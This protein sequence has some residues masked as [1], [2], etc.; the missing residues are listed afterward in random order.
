MSDRRMTVDANMPIYGKDDRDDQDDIAIPAMANSIFAGDKTAAVLARQGITGP[1]SVLALARV[2]RAQ[3]K[4]RIAIHRETS[5]ILEGTPYAGVHFGADGKPR[6]E[7]SDAAAKTR[8]LKASGAHQG[9]FL[10]HHE[11]YKGV[12]E[13]QFLSVHRMAERGAAYIGTGVYLGSNK[14]KNRSPMGGHYLPNDEAKGSNIHELQH[15][16]QGV[17]GFASGGSPDE[18]S[19]HFPGESNALTRKELYRRLAGEQEA[20]KARVRSD[21]TAEELRQLPPTEQ[22]YFL[23]NE[24]QIVIDRTGKVKYAPRDTGLKA[25]DRLEATGVQSRAPTNS[26]EVDGKPAALKRLDPRKIKADASTFQFKSGGDQS[27]VTDRLRSVKKWDPVSAGK[28][29]VFERKNGEHVIADGHQRRGLALRAVEAGQK[30]VKMDAYVFREKDGWSPE[31]VR[32]I[33]AMKNIREDSGTSLDMAKVMRDRPDLVDASIPLSSGKV[34][35]AQGLSRLSNDAFGMVANGAVKPD[36]AAAVGN[37]LRG[38]QGRDA[39]LLKEMAKAKVTSGQHARLYVSQA[40][41]APQITETHHG[42]FGAETMQR[43]LL[44]ER[45]AVLNKAMDAIRSDKRIFGMLTK[46]EGSIESA[47]NVLAKG[48]NAE[49]ATSAAQMGSLVEKLSTMTGPVSSMLDRAARAVAEGQKPAQAA[50]GFVGD[51]RT[52]MKTGGVGALTG[53]NAH[54]GWGDNARAASADVRAQRMADDLFPGPTT[55]DSLAAASRSKAAKGRTG[56]PMTEGL[57]GEQHKQTDLVDMAKAAIATNNGSAAKVSSMGT[58]GDYVQRLKDTLGTDKHEGVIREIMQDSSLGKADLAAIAKEHGMHATAS[59]SKPMIMRAIAQRHNKLIDAAHGSRAIFSSPSDGPIAKPISIP[60]RGKS[61]GAQKAPAA[62]SGYRESRVNRIMNRLAAAGDTPDHELRAKA[63]KMADGMKPSS[64]VEKPASGT[65][66]GW[67]DSARSA[68]LTKREENM[69]GKKKETFGEEITRRSKAASAA[70]DKKYKAAKASAA[71]P[72]KAGNAS[73]SRAEILRM[74]NDGIPKA[75]RVTKVADARYVL[76]STHGSIDVAK[77]EYQKRGMKFGRVQRMQDG[78]PRLS[79][80][81]AKT[82]PE[83]AKK[84]GKILNG[85]PTDFVAEGKSNAGDNTQKGNGRVQ[86]MADDAGAPKRARAPKEV[87]A[88]DFDFSKAKTYRKTAT[89]SA[90]QIKTAVGGESVVTRQPSKDGGSFVE[91]TNTAKPGDRIVTRSPGDSYVIPGEKFSKLYEPHPDQPGVYRSTNV[92]KAIRVNRDVSI[93]APWGEVQNI[94]KGGVIFKSETTGDVYGN[95][96]ETFN[97]DFKP[98]TKAKK[99][100]SRLRGTQNAT[101]QQAII[102]NRAAASTAGGRD[103]LRRAMADISAAASNHEDPHV[104]TRIASIADKAIKDHGA[105]KPSGHLETALWD[106]R[107][108]ANME[109]SS[110]SGLRDTALSTIQK[111]A[112]TKYIGDNQ[113][114]IQGNRKATAKPFVAPDPLKIIAVRNQTAASLAEQA[115]ATGN[116]SYGGQAKDL[117][118]RNDADLRRLS[119]TMTPDG[120]HFP[121][122]HPDSAWGKKLRDPATSAEFQKKLSDFNK[123]MGRVKESLGQVKDGLNRLAN[124][125]KAFTD[126]LKSVGAALS[127]K[128]GSVQTGS[129]DNDAHMGMSKIDH[130]IIDAIRGVGEGLSG[131][132]RGAMNVGVELAPDPFLNM[133]T[134]GAASIPAAAAI[135]VG[136]PPYAAGKAIETGANMAE[137]VSNSAHRN[138]RKAT[139]AVAA[140]GPIAVAANALKAAN[141]AKAKGESQIKAAARGAA[142]SAVG[143]GGAAV[144]QSA[145]TAGLVKF[146]IS[147][148]KAIPGVNAAMMAGGAAL[149]AYNAEKGH[150]LAGAAKGA[151]DMSLPGMVVNTAKDVGQA[152]SGRMALNAGAHHGSDHMGNFDAANQKFASAQPESTGKG[153]SKYWGANSAT[154]RNNRGLAPIDGTQ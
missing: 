8:M 91:T 80:S 50:R 83:A 15:F 64:A 6:F 54:V 57:F 4:N 29:I 7:I 62:V 139:A 107:A 109:R 133:A 76:E 56:D 24:Q 49:R 9:E 142:D 99:P 152:V 42:L 25:G 150:R 120:H 17:E 106:I 68:S 31:D 95:Q 63:E 18:F 67:S 87:S 59:M 74:A 144:A 16:V 46:N 85:L 88:S 143:M 35:E 101:N 129:V 128:S 145:A 10:T 12:P 60:S 124:P 111:Q 78:P 146:G 93:K 45:A 94:K 126:D 149:G 127:G 51:L 116:L 26:V 131:F 86:K 39:D 115:K 19:K 102:S 84:W 14:F 137:A 105:S 141:E 70:A 117:V 55:A 118:A 3:G 148:A 138:P 27:G 44:A 81:P 47:G 20:E 66:P 41:A 113:Q 33:A 122:I 134:R 79:S 132:G 154:G 89:L 61:A 69:A 75:Q 96:K 28:A 5:A 125:V 92:G 153:K 121:N 72:A 98:E 140:L 48:S 23:K 1:Q 130:P 30:N 11:L 43:S 38:D 135:G 123:S 104:F 82:T 103:G 36:V 58:T 22:P 114:A 119:G 52:A 73:V 77:A 136:V 90:D 97:A 112:R 13:A 151:W 100:T 34:K 32:A 2:L 108:K 40:V 53:G 110:P 147:A 21:L 37:G 71:A 65:K